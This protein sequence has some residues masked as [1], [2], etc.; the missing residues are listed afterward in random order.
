M[1]FNFGSLK[2]SKMLLFF[3]LQKGETRHVQYPTGG[4]RCVY[5]FGGKPGRFGN[6]WSN[7]LTSL[8]FALATSIC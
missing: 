2:H 7:F 3:G 5:F 4:L 8:A 6:R 1:F